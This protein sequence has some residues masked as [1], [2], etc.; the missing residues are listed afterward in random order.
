MSTWPAASCNCPSTCRPSQRALSSI[1]APFA[2]WVVTLWVMQP[3]SPASPC[4]TPEISGEEQRKQSTEAV[5][6]AG[7]PQPQSRWMSEL[8]P[9]LPVEQ[10]CWCMA[11]PATHP[12]Y[13]AVKLEE[14]ESRAEPR[15]IY[16]Q[17]AAGLLHFRQGAPLPQARL[18]RGVC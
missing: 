11:F 16:E 14:L 9:L 8:T 13:M 17:G 7:C 6:T 4:S 2:L 5:P 10:H 3:C 15:E 12:R 1:L 18:P